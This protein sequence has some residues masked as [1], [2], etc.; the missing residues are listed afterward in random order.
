MTAYDIL[1]AYIEAY[2][3]GILD[4]HGDAAVR[5]LKAYAAKYHRPMTHIGCEV[6][7]R[8]AR[9]AAKIRKWEASGQG[10]LF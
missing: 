6:V 4:L 10:R 8:V 3:E 2:G 9:D 5:E 1:Q 7:I